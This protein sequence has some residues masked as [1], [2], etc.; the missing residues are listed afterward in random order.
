MSDIPVNSDTGSNMPY[1]TVAELSGAIKKTIEGQFEFVRVRGEISRPSMPASGHIYFTLK[2]AQVSLSAVIWKGMAASM[3]VRPEEG[4]DVICSGKITTFGG[5]SKYQIIVNQMEVA[6]EGALLKQLEDRRKRLAA[7]GLFDPAQKQ[8]IPALPRRIGVVTSPSGAVIR[9]I[10]HRLSERFGTH[11]MVWGVPVQGQGAETKIAEAINGFNALPEHGDVAR[12]DLLIVARGGGSLEDLWC[13]NEEIV[14]RAVADSKIA[15][16]SAVGHETDTTL[17]DYASDLRAPTPTAAAEI[18]TPVARELQTRILELETR[19]S[20]AISRRF[21]TAE[22]MLRGAGRGLLHPAELIGRQAQHLDM[23]TSQ[24]HTK[25][26]R[27]IGDRQI[28]VSR[29]TDRLPAPSERLSKVSDRLSTASV[30]LEG[31]LDQKL[32]GLTQSLSGLDRLLQANSF[33]RVL[34]RGFALIVSE[35]GETVKRA[36]E[37]DK[38]S[39]IQIRFA[40]AVRAAQLDDSDISAAT[41][42]NAIKSPKGVKKTVLKSAKPPSQTE[43]F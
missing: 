14:V 26:E 8:E 21:D 37:L 10:L 7:E 18:A 1:F 16:I 12:P 36:S 29:L 42:E 27:Q 4:L 39:K 33:E 20:G 32:F 11:V 30:R 38:G 19:L 25:M 41:T 15:V 24:L 13:F 23:L 5:Q 22:T 6:G 2:D 9:D 40:D 28:Q 17:I 34:D 43:L 31:L 3:V 35:T